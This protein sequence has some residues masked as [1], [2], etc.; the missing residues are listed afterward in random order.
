MKKLVVG[1]LYAFC[2]LTAVHSGDI[3][4]QS[5]TGT[6]T[7]AS[8]DGTTANLITSGA[9]HTWTGV[10]TGTVPSGCATAGP[11][12]GGPSPIYD[13]STNTVSFS[14]NANA[15][16][17]QTIAINNALSSV[18]AGVKIGGYNYSYDIRNMNGDDR[19]GGI[20]TLN[21]YQSL[22]G[23]NGSALLSSQQTYN[24]KFEWMSVTGTK[25]TATPID[26]ANA[27]YLK[28]S[29]TGGDNGYWGGYFGP[30]VRNV[31]MSLN[32]VATPVT[33]HTMGDDG[34]VNVPLQFGFPFYGKVFTNSFMFDNGVVGLFDPVAGGCNPANG[35]CG[36]Q[37]WNSE[38]FSNNMGNQ[39]SYMIAPLWADLAP[40]NNTR[41]LTQGD[42]TFQKYT[43]ENIGQYYDQSK[44]QTFDL[45]IKPSGFIGVNYGQVNLNQTNISVGTIGNP[46][47]GEYNQIAYHPAGTTVTGLNNWTL[48]N[49]PDGCTSN[50]LSSPSCPGYTD[51]MCSTNPLYATTCPGYQQAYF[52]QQCSANPLYS[53][54]CPGYAAAYL[55]Q[56]CSI[57]PLYSTTC[58][59][60]D[61]AYFNQQCSLDPLYNSRCTGYETAY[62]DQQCSISPLYAT[63]CT[64]YAAAYKTQQCSLNALYA[65]DCP[66]YDQAY[67]NAQCLIDSLYSTQCEGYKTAYAIKYLVG[68]ESAVTTAVNT[69]LTNTVETQ[70]NDPANVTGAVDAYATATGTTSATTSTSSATSATTSATSVSPV[71]V[72]STVK[73]T[74]PAPVTATVAQA[75]PKKEEAKK[76]EKKDEGSKSNGGNSNGPSNSDSKPS[77]G[78][79][80]ARQE[81]AEK[82]REAAAKEAVA[83]G[84]DLANEMG[85][86]ADM[87]SQKA[88]Q[89][90]VIQA[91]GFTPGFDTYN[92]AMLP[93]SRFYAPKIVYGGQVN[94]DNKNVSRRL[95]GGSDRVHQ[96]MV[97][98]QYNRG[99]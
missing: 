2:A 97:D 47:L 40:N 24:T 63:D 62:H 92:K 49:T 32:Y 67:L 91:M 74:A 96:D 17:A 48:N 85:K 9:N 29:M 76:E 58:D 94:V 80:T 18:G 39:F 36:G 42:T 28:F 98:S 31:S 22:I 60:Y 84:K 33:Q 81:L 50:P 88:V 95:M 53:Q 44:L 51:A 35:Y 8:S 69:S 90:V 43:W 65:T 27:S 37:Q 56:Q 55:I 5:T 66:G 26:Q 30:Q 21:V 46:A 13:P 12:P 99:N 61:T 52:S 45:T 11:C 15:T 19:Q 16:V 79:K 25:S 4:A 14:Y 1:M 68:L 10:T 75:E 73:P 71:A 34:W 57:N 38:P 59:G 77:D 7:T 93:D 64:G 54:A 3:N 6:T 72:I 83:K 41:Y 23:T 89:N 78:P 86:A 20:D 70:R 87:E 82:R